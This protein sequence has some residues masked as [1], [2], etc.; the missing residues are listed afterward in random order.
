MASDLHGVSI[1]SYKHGPEA[2]YEKETGRNRGLSITRV[3]ASRNGMTRYVPW[4]TV[5]AEQRRHDSA[6]DSRLVGR[7]AIQWR[8]G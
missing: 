3:L 1:R 7:Y 4:N 8:G 5:A 6:A 2:P